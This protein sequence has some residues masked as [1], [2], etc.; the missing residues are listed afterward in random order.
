MISRA[1]WNPV[2][3]FLSLFNFSFGKAYK[4]SRCIVQLVSQTGLFNGTLQ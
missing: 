1:C 3:S 4:E 2:N